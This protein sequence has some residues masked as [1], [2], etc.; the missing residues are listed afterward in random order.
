MTFWT[1]LC[2][3]RPRLLHPNLLLPRPR[4]RLPSIPLS[5]SPSPRLLPRQRSPPPPPR[6]QQ[7]TTRA[8]P[9]WTLGAPPMPGRLQRL[10]KRPQHPLPPH[11][12]PARHQ[13]AGAR[14][15]RRKSL[16]T[17]ILEG[18]VALHL[19]CRVPLLCLRLIL[20]H[21]CPTPIQIQTRSQ[22]AGLEAGMICS[23][24]FGSKIVG[25]SGCNRTFVGKASQVGGQSPPVEGEHGFPRPFQH[26]V[27][28]GVH[29]MN[30]NL[31]P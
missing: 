19:P 1:F 31:G 12:M 8:S 10:P 23:P 15:R 2:L 24:T 25:C 5:T 6:L 7:Q 21:T 29:R 9:T 14:V 30:C 4:R 27:R 22:L 17:T 26:S 20:M 28:H 13:A 3:R 11:H 18:G 16:K